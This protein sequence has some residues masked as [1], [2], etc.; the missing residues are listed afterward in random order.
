MNEIKILNIVSNKSASSIL[1]QKFYSAEL[2]YV[3]NIIKIDYVVEETP[4]SIKIYIKKIYNEID[5]WDSIKNNVI[6][7]LSTHHQNDF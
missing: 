6:S 7:L 3:N 2:E 4:I 1:Y 5:F